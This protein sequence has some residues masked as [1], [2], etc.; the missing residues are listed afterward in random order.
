[1]VGR[2]TLQA[3][4]TSD[5]V[6]LSQPHSNTTPSNGLALM[7]SS[8]SMLTRLRYNM[9]V[10]LIRVSPKDITGNSTGN[11]HASDTPR[12]TDMASSLKCALHGV[13]SDQVLHIPIIG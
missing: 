10:G 6:V 12:F 9:A 13:N 3:P 1:M 4:I 7:D 11:P 5:G 2:S 8:T